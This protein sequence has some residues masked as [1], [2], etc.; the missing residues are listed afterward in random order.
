M[1]HSGGTQEGLGVAQSAAVGTAITVVPDPPV[2]AAFY[3]AARATD[4]AVPGHA[5]VGGVVEDSFAQQNDFRQGFALDRRDPSQQ[6][7]LRARCNVRNVVDGNLAGQ[8]VLHEQA[9][10][11]V[12]GK[13]LGCEPGVRNGR[14]QGTGS[15]I[16]HIHGVAALQ[17]D[18]CV[19]APGVEGHGH[20]HRAIIE[21]AAGG[22]DLAICAQVQLRDDRPGRR[23]ERQRFAAEMKSPARVVLLRGNPCVP[24]V[25]G[26]GDCRQVVRHA[27]APHRTVRT[28]IDGEL[29]VPDDLHRAGIHLGHH[30]VVH[31]G[32]VACDKNPSA[33]CGDCDTPGRRTHVDGAFHRA[34]PDDL[35]QTTRGLQGHVGGIAAGVKC[36]PVGP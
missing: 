26:D 29:E 3:V 20:R 28:G 1:G 34:I 2:A 35:Q 19:S 33:V 15:G 7:N 30:A 31:R 36:N 14:R 18:E 13:P 27:P 22:E 23:L 12:D 25:R 21:V 10:A 17:R 5:R 4:V 32:D 6:R 9:T 11:S 16:E 24:P 8:E